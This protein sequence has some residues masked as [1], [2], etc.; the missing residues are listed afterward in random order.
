MKY[1]F[2]G[3]GEFFQSRSALI[4][5]IPF[6]IS[7]HFGWSFRPMDTPSLIV[8]ASPTR[9][10][11][12]VKLWSIWVIDKKI[13]CTDTVEFGNTSLN[14]WYEYFSINSIVESS[15]NKVPFHTCVGVFLRTDHVFVTTLLKFIIDVLQEGMGSMKIMQGGLQLSG[16]TLITDRLVATAIR[17]RAGRPILI[18]SSA[19]ITLNARNQQGRLVNSLKLSKHIRYQ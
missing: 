1:N 2:G 6:Y 13:K 14:I 18:E 16:R 8:T 19:N 11:T 4:F 5:S 3:V 12:P 10:K 7:K 17:S 15:S 9:A